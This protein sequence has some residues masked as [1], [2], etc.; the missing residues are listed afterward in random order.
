VS[1]D[2]QAH[3]AA[4]AVR[5]AVLS[6]GRRLKAERPADGRP[7]L[8]LSVLGHLR[9]RG[10][11]TP[12]DLASAERVQPQTLTRTLTSLE[13]G[14]LVARTVHPLDGRRAVLA[15]TEA[16]LDALSSDMA[17]RDD[18]LAAAMAECLTGTERE[19]LRLASELLERLAEAPR[20]RPSAAA[21]ARTARRC[22]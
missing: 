15:L 22:R 2:E 18:W 14:G 12:G 20:T 7:S 17:V 1:T 10:P 3:E 11:M 9:R 16:G 13:H 19:L 8:E 5:R 6:I 4:V 21:D